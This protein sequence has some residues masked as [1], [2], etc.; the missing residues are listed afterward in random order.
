MASIIVR[1]NNNGEVTGYQ[2][3]IRRKGFPPVSKT[4]SRRADA[5]RYAREVE[6]EMER[7]AFVSLAEAQATTLAEALDRY[8]REVSSRKRGYKQE[9]YKL[10]LWRESPLAKRSLASLRSS[11]F[12]AWRDRRLAAG[13]SPATVRLDLAL[14]SHLF[15]IAEKEW[16]IPVKNPVRSIRLPPVSN[17]RDRRLDPDE[18][19]RLLDVLRQSPNKWALPIVQI[20]LETA[21]R[22]GEILSLTW[23]DIDLGRRTAQLRRTKN[24]EPRTVPLSSRAVEILSGL[25]KS[26][27]G[28]VFPVSSNAVKLLFARACMRAGIEDLHFHDLRHEATSRLAEKLPNVIELTAVTGHKDLRM[29]KRYYHP[30]A[31][32]LARKLG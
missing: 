10:N 13:A 17:A 12:A 14:I 28:R 16:G 25:P 18:E 15:T 20:A 8:E 21:M 23:K 9:R 26:I 7:G 27:D 30:R 32:D 24:G 31:E 11:D 5:E 19:A 29:L 2:A 3:R 4:F 1:K 6:V 22:Q